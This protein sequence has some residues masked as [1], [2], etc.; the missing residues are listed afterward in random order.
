[1]LRIAAL[2]VDSV[3][4][5]AIADRAADHSDRDT[6]LLQ[7]KKGRANPV[8]FGYVDNFVEIC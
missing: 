7:I 2:V 4:A 6:N 3:A 8:L 1:M 5:P